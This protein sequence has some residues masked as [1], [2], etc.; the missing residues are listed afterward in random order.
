M[1]GSLISAGASLLGGLLG[2][3][4]AD[5]SRKSAEMMAAQ[6]IAQ[7]REFAQQGIRWK[8]EDAKA[9][10]I[11]PLYA[12]GAST[13]S[14]SPVSANFTAD[15]SMPNALASAGQDIGRAVNATRSTNERADAFATAANKLALEKGQLENEVLK[16]DVASRAARLRQQLNPPMPI[17]Q[18]Y[19]TGLDG[20][21][22]AATPITVSEKNERISPD[23]QNPHSEAFAVADVG[24]S[25]TA[26]GGYSVVP[27]KDV[28][29]RIEDN[30]LQQIM[31]SF[32][33]NVLPSMGENQVPPPV[34]VPAGY[35]KWLYH[36]FYQEY[37]PH[38][39]IR[40]LD[41]VPDNRYTWWLP[42]YY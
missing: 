18:R 36:P 37:R 17:G 38:K 4:S 1:I 14:F 42:R 32:R 12:L 3:S 8:V 6:N 23:P 40:A 7:Q 26:S 31:W 29:E 28:Q 15:T 24:H 39:R 27:S 22:A 41:W 10:G 9:A 19:M 30:W 11:H 34:P 2:K 33:N 13:P 5:D 20:Q 35:D 21:S 16:L 25:R